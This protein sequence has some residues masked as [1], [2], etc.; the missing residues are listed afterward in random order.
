MKRLQA[1]LLLLCCWFIMS[2]GGLSS[3]VDDLEG[4]SDDDDSTHDDD[5]SDGPCEDGENR[6]DGDM[7]TVC[8][9]GEWEE[10]D[11]CAGYGQVCTLRK[12]EHLCADASDEDDEDDKE[13]DTESSDETET[14][15]EKQEDSD[16]G[17]T[18]DEKKIDTDDDDKK[19]T[20]DEKEEDPVEPVE[21]KYADDCEVFCLNLSHCDLKTPTGDPYKSAISWFSDQRHCA[22]NCTT[23]TNEKLELVMTSCEQSEFDLFLCEMNVKS[24]DDLQL[25]INADGDAGDLPCGDEME[26]VLYDCYLPGD[27]D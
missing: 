6:C 18:A 16:E 13:E 23:E 11:D 8:E 26:D 24:C 27:K 17:D 14:D 20:E 10:W 21:G 19:D 1:V 9:D 7:L 2:C 3:N 12:G 25:L 5:Q 4:N 15:D 22:A